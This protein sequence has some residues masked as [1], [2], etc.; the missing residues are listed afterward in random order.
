MWNVDKRYLTKCIV[1][2]KEQDW[3]SLP[4]MC[5]VNKSGPLTCSV[6]AV[7]VVVAAVVRIGEKEGIS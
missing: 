5:S 3:R 7:V 1:I 2:H 6:R 4:T